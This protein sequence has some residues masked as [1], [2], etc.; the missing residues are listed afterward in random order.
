MDRLKEIQPGGGF[1]L[2]PEAATEKMRSIINKPVSSEQLLSTARAVFSHGWANL[3]LY[4]MIGHPNESLAD[5]RAI[6][7][8]CK[9]VLAEGRK[10]IGGR[11]R[12]H[13]G[14]GTFIP[15]PHTPFQWV[16]CDSTQQ[17]EEKLRL[18]KTELRHPN[19]KLS[20]NH[21]EDSLLEAWLARG[22]RR[23]GQVIS[24]SLAAWGE[25]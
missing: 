6:A 20:W 3:K 17:I 13:A 19:I 24:Q 21:P 10:I 1:T 14:I 25:I 22:D 4:F 18:L 12:L 23:L 11:A 9:A 2:A 15:K 8:L 5:V 7:E 16:A